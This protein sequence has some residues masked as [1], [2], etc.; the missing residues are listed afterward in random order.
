MRGPEKVPPVMGITTRFP[1]GTLP[2]A[3]DSPRVQFSEYRNVRP[4]VLGTTICAATTGAKATSADRKY[5]RRIFGDV[6]FLVDVV[7]DDI[8]QTIS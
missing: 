2:T 7:V 3:R 5:G 4:G 6:F 1:S 8:T